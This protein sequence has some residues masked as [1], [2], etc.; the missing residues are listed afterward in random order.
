MAAPG[1]LRRRRRLPAPGR[2]LEHISKLRIVD[3]VAGV[4]WV[5]RPSDAGKAVLFRGRGTAQNAVQ[6]PRKRMCPV[7]RCA[8]E[9]A[10]STLTPCAAQ[11]GIQRSPAPTGDQT[12]A[13]APTDDDG[14]LPSSAMAVDRPGAG[15]GRLRAS[16]ESGRLNSGF[17]SFA[18]T[19]CS[20]EPMCS[21]FE[22][23]RRR[24][25]G[26]GGLR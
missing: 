21:H 25:S 8:L 24:G 18:P 10:L 4:R 20:R 9:R 22:E 11:V 2:L 14:K 23:G 6:R 3:F 19:A 12:P 7:L 5:V 13:S 16:Q 17:R 1:L 26:F 15:G